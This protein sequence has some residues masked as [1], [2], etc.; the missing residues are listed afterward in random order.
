MM[1]DPRRDV[2]HEVANRLRRRGVH[3]TGH[4]TDDELVRVLEAVER[5]EA[6]VEELGGDLM[7]DEPV[8]D[9]PPRQPDD[10]R[11]VLPRRHGNESVDTFVTRIVLAT[12]RAAE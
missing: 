4:E 10:E 5:F 8:D 7:V 1:S 2:A 12:D 6:I 11:F 3:L 9:G